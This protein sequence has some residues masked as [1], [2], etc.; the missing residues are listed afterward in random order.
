MGQLMDGDIQQLTRLL[1]N[2]AAVGSFRLGATV[3]LTPDEALQLLRNLQ[4]LDLAEIG[5]KL[6]TRSVVGGRSGSIR[7]LVLPFI[8]FLKEELGVEAT[9]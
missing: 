6:Y 9:G 1:P 2:V 4:A 7:N 5:D 3:Q 8:D